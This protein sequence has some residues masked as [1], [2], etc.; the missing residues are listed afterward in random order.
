MSEPLTLAELMAA[1]AGRGRAIATRDWRLPLD[2]FAHA[3]SLGGELDR[4]EGR[5]VALAVGDMAK[6][7]AA[8]I[9]LDGLARRIVLCPPGLDRAGLEA[10]ICGAQADAL[11]YDGDRH[12][13]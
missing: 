2:D 5:S 3:T 10:L 13:E 8:L 9:E 4:L 11:V 12:D 1:G 6:A 7:A